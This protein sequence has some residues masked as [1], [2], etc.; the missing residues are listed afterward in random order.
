MRS[1]VFVYMNEILGFICLAVWVYLICGRGG[2]WRSN[3]RD[4]ARLPR[5]EGGWPS[6]AVVIPARNESESIGASVQSLLRQDYRGSLGIFVVDDDSDDDTAAIAARTA[7]LVPERQ[8][9]VIAGKG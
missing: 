5:E 6:V 9:T 3:I 7:V 4:S 8:L 2:F 1:D